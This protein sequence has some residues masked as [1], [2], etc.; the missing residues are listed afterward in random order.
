[1]NADS[2]EVIAVFP[3]ARPRIKYPWG[4]LEVN[5]CFL[6]HIGNRN[7]VDVQANYHKQT[8]PDR[9]FTSVVL[10]D[11]PDMFAVFRIK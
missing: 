4:K 1:M 11:D 9:T 7:R 10:P 6:T 2:P 5:E 8:F 3:E